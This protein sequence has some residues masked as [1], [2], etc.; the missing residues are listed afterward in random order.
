MCAKEEKRELLYDGE[1]VQLYRVRVQKPTGGF[2]EKE[3][4]AHPGAAV[5]LPIVNDGRVCLIKN[6]R[7]SAGQTLLELPA[8]TLGK[9]EDPLVAAQREL[10]E[11]TGYTAKSWK[12]LTEFW[13]AP[14]VY[15]EKMWLYLARDLTPGQ[16]RLDDTEQIEVALLPWD[17][18]V[19]LAL[20]GQIQ[21]AKTILGLLLW[22]RLRHEE[23][24]LA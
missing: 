22:D 13:V 1:R 9:N 14:G 6:W 23:S 4:I 17:Q 2:A 20:R 7:Y 15:G 21:D 18:A 3:F 5:I 11:E 10:T 19:S 8:G 12:I 16:Q 24:K